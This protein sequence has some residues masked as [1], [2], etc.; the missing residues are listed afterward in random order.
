MQNPAP[1]IDKRDTEKIAEEI[2]TLAPY[3][4][5]ELDLSDDAGAGIALLKIFSR[6]QKLVIDRLN[7]VPPKNFVAFLDM[8]G[9]GL[10]PAQPARAPVTF[11]LAE[12]TTENVPIP[13]K[14]Q[15]AAGEVVFETDAN[16]VAT[17]SKLTKAYSIDVANDRIYESPPGIISGD[18]AVAFGAKLLYDASTGDEK[19]FVNGNEGLNKDDL[20]VIGKGTRVDYGIVS[21]V[22]DSRVTLLHK[23]EN[24]HD[25]GSLVEKVTS[26]ELFKGKNLQEHILYLGHKDLFN[27]KEASEIRI[28][29]RS[30]SELADR[31]L[32]RWE[33]WGEDDEKNVGWHLLTIET[34]TQPADKAVNLKKGCAGEIK[35]QKIDGIESRWIRC[36]TRDG[37]I[38]E[39]E[40]IR[41]DTLQIGVGPGAGQVLQYHTLSPQ[42]IR[43]VG[44]TFG[45]R[46][47]TVGIDTIEELLEFND[48]VGDLAR[49][50]SGGS[51][52]SRYHE[53][54][55]NILENAQK[56]ILDT[57]YED[58]IAKEHTV[59]RGVPP[60]L[61]FHNDAPMDLTTSNGH[62]TTPIY[63]FGTAPRTY[64]TFHIAS[65]EALSKKGSKIAIDVSVEP[66]GPGAPTAITF[67]DR[68]AETEKIKVFARGS[69]GRL[70]EVAIDPDGNEEP[71]W[72]DHGFP[73]DTT[74]ALGSTPCI[75][76]DNCEF[77][78]VFAR[79]ENGNLVERLYNG[80]Q[81]QWI[82]LESPGEGVDV[83]FDPAAVWLSK[84]SCVAVFVAGTDGHLHRWE[85]K[86]SQKA[87]TPWADLETAENAVRV[88]GSPFATSSGGVNAHL[89]VR[90]SDGHLHGWNS[91]DD[92]WDDTDYGLPGGRTVDSRPFADLFYNYDPD[93]VFDGYYAKIFI[94]DDEGV[95]WE[96]DTL[97]KDWGEPLG[98]PSKE[99]NHEKEIR[100]SSGP[101]G[102]ILKPGPDRANEDKHIFVRGTDDRLWERTDSDD[103]IPH[104]AP[105]NSELCHAPSALSAVHIFSASS[106]NSIIE[107]KAIPESEHVWNEYKDSYET[108]LT[109]VLSWEY[110]NGKGWV[111]L[112]GIRDGT[113]DLLK[114]G[115]ITCDLPEDIDETEVSGQKSY[116]IRA[117][118]VGGDYGTETFFLSRIANDG[119]AQQLISTKN[120]IRPPI[121]NSLTISYAIEAYPERCIAHNNLEYLDHSEACKSEGKR[122]S[123]FVGLEDDENALYLGFDKQLEKGPI[124]IFFAAKELA[125]T[126]EANPKL[127]WKHSTR[128][129][130]TRL[131]YLD[132]TKALV[133][134]DIL[135]LIGSPDF[136]ASSCLGSYLYW[137]KATLIEGGYEGK[138]SPVLYGIYPNTAWVSQAETVEDEIL[139]SGD[140]T[141]D[142]EFEFA[143]IPVITAEI[144]VDEMATLSED[145]KNA[146]IE[147][148][149][150][151]SVSEV[152]DESGKTPKVWVLWQAVDDF[153]DSTQASR[154]YLVDRVTGEAR[155]GN[156]VHGMV[157][158]VGADNIRATYQVGGGEGGNVP[159]FEITTLKT[160]IPYVDSVA[161]PWS[162][163]G[164]ADVELLG[165]AMERGPWGIKHRDRA[166]TIEDFEWL[167][168]QASRDVARTKCMKEATGMEV[169]SVTVIIL[170]KS[171]E[172]KPVPSFELENVVGKYLSDRCSNVIALRVNGPVY[173]EVSV[174]LDVYPA[175]IDM[176]AVAENETLDRLKSFLHPLTGGTAG[177]GWGFGRLVCTSDIYSLLEG[178]AE[179]DHVERVETRMFE[180][181]QGRRITVSPDANIPD[182]LVCSGEHQ[183]TLKLEGVA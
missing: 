137:I 57:N 173:I 135:E 47:S 136:S 10:L 71:L 160:A 91:I 174:S 165:D 180:T 113:T 161:N 89:F 43:G 15:I 80:D 132:A 139:G 87:T 175:S 37:K 42:A 133:R 183:V 78:A 119:D 84:A 152:K 60:D 101:D 72:T 1:I 82:D 56:H 169:G 167:A 164:G 14:T 30:Y 178:I 144:W 182:A 93:G 95:L 96:F 110:W 2:R 33:Y 67:H 162:A 32:V 63:P 61:A 49:I 106:K 97:S 88:D 19:I 170:P 130:W 16:M 171:G 168:R 148:Y 141:A 154:H 140:G 142:Q 99:K 83:K 3:Y 22:S 109:P 23:L 158:P 177:E 75:A 11:Y 126:K 26:F 92:C 138:E 59:T 90:G 107:R 44:K 151:N 147:E 166:V 150:G 114:S 181:G 100:V 102:C 149:G 105:A 128:N 125:L 25:A 172:D 70:V 8:I 116:W 98:I 131:G 85:Q 58:Q 134:A 13:E 118:I 153:F 40:S 120:S 163:G 94:K 54:A 9:M 36:R 65:Q 69:Y 159:E 145:E 41:L 48:R 29:T 179:I 176:A 35:E 117:R 62:F 12:G 46:L 122:F 112:K 121:I 18:R 76:T 24:S 6:M 77:I 86:L 27:I 39:T 81:W 111:A 129:G 74:I 53:R 51:G 5:P 127:G 156:G 28:K 34:P 108:A 68:Q 124:N 17:P 123:P 155:F 4:V 21:E 66:R 45:K 7:R 157:P 38:R 104:E 143:K 73:P 79:A 115:Q 103:W 146:I 64:D 20:L 50:L 55:E 52:P 31:D